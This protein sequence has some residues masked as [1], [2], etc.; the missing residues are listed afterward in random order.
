MM[1]H[2]RFFSAMV[3]TVMLAACA[4]SNQINEGPRVVAAQSAAYESSGDSN[5]FEHRSL[6]IESDTDGAR[7]ASEARSSDRQPTIRRLSVAKPTAVAPA[8]AVFAADADEV[9]P[10][11]IDN[12]SLE[13][14]VFSIGQADSM[15][16]RGPDANLLID[17]GEVTWNSRSNFSKVR[18]R[19][20]EITGTNHIDYLMVSHFHGDHAGNPDRYTSN[21]V[22][23]ARSGLFGLLG[24]PDNP[25]TVGT[26]IDRGEYAQEY[27]S[28]R[29]LIHRG[30]IAEEQGW[31][32]S[33]TV[34]E[35]VAP[36][37]FGKEL[38][39]LGGDIE[40]DILAVGGRVFD[41]DPGAMASAAIAHPEDYETLPVSQNDFSIALEIS[42]GDF[43]FFTGGDLT[44]RSKNDQ[45][46][47]PFEDMCVTINNEIYTN[48]EA[49]M[50]AHWIAEDRESR[51]EIY[52]ANHHGSANS[53][54]PALLDALDPA[55]VVY[56]TGGL[57]KHPAKLVATR[58]AHVEQLITTKE[59]S[60]LE[61]WPNGF[62]AAYGHGWSNPVGEIHISVD[63][64]GRFFSID[65]SKPRPDGTVAEQGF[66]YQSSN[67]GEEAPD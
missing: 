56:S 39:Q 33:N 41:G 55:I 57:H 26:L 48:V 53:S 62:P 18:D 61:A 35:R 8:G 24:D 28:E 3:L 5:D 20:A 7:L 67:D 31:I 40:I 60:H 58:L 16:V 6:E 15:L 37:P 21:N 38:I 49:H 25:T 13:I 54:T 65:T 42:V 50:V 14:Y 4:A 63:Q 1:S 52:R 45:G 47:C 44:G 23:Y 51:V 46:Q 43:E 27:R 11:F 36:P 2:T 66:M 64:N 59:S 29:H 34:T 12:P 19:V 22:F 9:W 30:I 32:G 10:E 17:I